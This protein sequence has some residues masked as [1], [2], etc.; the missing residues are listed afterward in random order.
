MERFALQD[1]VQSTGGRLRDVELADARFSRI[2]TDSRE[3]E[4]GDIFWAL[5]G[6]HQHGHD[7]VSQAREKQARLNF[8]LRPH[9][10]GDAG[11]IKNADTQRKLNTTTNAA[12]NV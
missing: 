7:F 3:I 10:H 1:L 5:K 8:V 2:S 12:T 6:E 11:R 9:W 4:P